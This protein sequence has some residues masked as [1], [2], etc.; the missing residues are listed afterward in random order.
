MWAVAN[1]SQLETKNMQGDKHPTSALNV[2]LGTF[3][4]GVCYLRKLVGTTVNIYISMKVTD[5]PS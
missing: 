3:V 2:M 5:E 4:S 1:G